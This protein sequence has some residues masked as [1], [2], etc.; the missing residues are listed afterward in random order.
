MRDWIVTDDVAM[1]GF[2]VCVAAKKGCPKVTCVDAD[3]VNDVAAMLLGNGVQPAK[4]GA[5]AFF[6]SWA[7]AEE[8]GVSEPVVWT[9]TTGGRQAIR[10]GSGIRDFREPDAVFTTAALFRSG[11]FG[12][13]DWAAPTTRR[14]LAQVRAVTPDLLKLALSHPSYF[15]QCCSQNTEG[16]ALV[17]P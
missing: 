14:L 15:L 10:M 13:M 6:V 3:K 11:V 1:W 5:R 4:G 12:M 2:P 7:W 16:A 8:Q 17:A 9:E